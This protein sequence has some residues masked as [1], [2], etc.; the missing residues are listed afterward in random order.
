LTHDRDRN[1]T[2]QRF[3]RSAARDSDL[4][5]ELASRTGM[6][7]THTPDAEVVNLATHRDPRS[8][9]DRPG[10]DGTPQQNAALRIL[11]GV[12]G[13]ALAYQGARQGTWT[14]RALAGLG[15]SLAWW[16]LTNECDLED[17]RR[18]VTRTLESIWPLAD[19][20][21][22]QASAE[23]FPASDAPSW[24]PTVGTGIRHARGR[25]R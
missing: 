19:D 22:Q 4:A 6:T 7:E 2:H 17:T 3:R 5:T 11:L 20:Q 9:W 23:S 10:W 25:A 12:G 15:G 24:T 21:V 8:V 16:A 18:W 14:G 1:E 13:A